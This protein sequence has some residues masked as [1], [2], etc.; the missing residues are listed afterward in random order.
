MGFYTD[1]PYPRCFPREC[2]K[3]TI[4]RTRRGRIARRPFLPKNIVYSLSPHA[5]SRV[6][7]RGFNLQ[8]L[9]TTVQAKPAPQLANLH[10]NGQTERTHSSRK[11]LQNPR[12]GQT[13][14]YHLGA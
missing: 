9:W 4:A 8:P 7:R 12:T 1:S 3:R 6:Y 14:A 2:R 13:P 5:I 10:L 11:S